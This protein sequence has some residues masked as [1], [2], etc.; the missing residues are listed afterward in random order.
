MI[1]RQEIYCHDCGLYV[2]FDIDVELNGNHVLHCPNCGHEHCRVVDNG[3]ITDVRWDQRNGNNRTYLVSSSTV[4]TAAISIYASS[5]TTA[6]SAT[7]HWFLS[8]AWLNT[9]ST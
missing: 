7:G 9:T 4:T 5:G 8:Q 3:R 1:E 6:T 2:H